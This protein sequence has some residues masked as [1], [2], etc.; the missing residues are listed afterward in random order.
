M[1]TLAA[2]I[3]KARLDARLTQTQLGAACGVTPQAVYGWES[4][5][6]APDHVALGIIAQVTSTT[7]QWLISGQ[8]AADNSTSDE[9]SATHWVGRV[10]PSLQWQQIISF[11]TNGLE[12]DATARSHFNC[13]PRSFQTVII[14]KSNEPHINQHD[15][16]IIDPDLKPI[17]GDHI[18]VEHAGDI[19]LRRYRPREDHIELAPSNPDWPS[20]RVSPE[21]AKIIGVVAETSRPRRV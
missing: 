14:D 20:L 11:L 18:L 12:P 16:I 17:P 5:K 6:F 3:K 21:Q 8:I 19:Y 13:G 9:R 1:P 2:R 15:S 7:L 10:V 4:G